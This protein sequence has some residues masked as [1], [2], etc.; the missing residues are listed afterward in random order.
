MQNETSENPN[1]N[2]QLSERLLDFAAS[3]IKTTTMLTKGEA[4][5]HIFKQ[6]MR[7]STSAGANYE[8]ARAAESRADF[9]HKLQIVLKELRESIYWLRLTQKTDLMKVDQ[10]V[11]EARELTNIIAKSV[12]TARK[13][14]K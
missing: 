6:L 5:C 10:L 4:S 7:S 8:E 11:Q 12:V 3:I 14:A 2:N 9:I 13:R 1:R